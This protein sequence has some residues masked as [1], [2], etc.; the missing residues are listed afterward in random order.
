MNKDIYNPD[1]VRTL[2]NSMSKTYERMNYITSFGFSERWRRIC[3]KEAQINPGDH[4]ADLMTGM[5]ECWKTILPRIGQNGTLTAL[6]FSSEMLSHAEKRKLTCINFKIEILCEDVF[7][8]TIPDSSI[9]CVVSGFGIKTF[10]EKQ[11]ANLA[12]EINRILKPNGRFSLIDVSVPDGKVLSVLY[13]FYLKNIIP[14]LGKLFLGNPE[15]YKMLGVYTE[16]F[17]NAQ[18]C[19][20]I[21]EKLGFESK[22]TKKFFG[23]ASGITGKKKLAS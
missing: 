2:F 3:V 8:N 1:F 20:A 5:G 21:F 18:Q 11:L 22:F 19:H 17:R 13:M 10:S 7:K 16:E 12:L 23:C 15:N 6:D 9:D 14:I 4:V